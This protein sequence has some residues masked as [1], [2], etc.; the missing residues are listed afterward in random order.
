MSAVVEHVI[1]SMTKAPADA[2]L[3]RDV[4]S[5]TSFNGRQIRASTFPL[6]GLVHDDLRQRQ[7]TLPRALFGRVEMW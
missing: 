5:V 3:R 1:S 6:T 7:V 2:R 4:L